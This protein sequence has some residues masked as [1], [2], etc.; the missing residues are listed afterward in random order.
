VSETDSKSSSFLFG[1]LVSLARGT[2]I[3]MQLR[4]KNSV[5][6]RRPQSSYGLWALALP[7]VRLELPG[8]G[9]VLSL[10]RT[11]VQ[12]DDRWREAGWQEIRCKMH[13]YRVRLDLSSSFD[14][15]TYFLARYC[16]LDTELVMRQMLRPG[17]QFID[18]GANIG[19]LTLMAAHLVGPTG[20]IHAFEPNPRM[21]QRLNEH[22]D[23]NGLHDRVIA[24]PVG[25]SN[26]EADLPF[27]IVDGGAESGTVA[28]LPDDVAA[29]VTEQMTIHVVPGDRLLGGALT[30]DRRT[31]IKLDVEGH[32][33]EAVQGM[34]DT[35]DRLRPV[36]LTEVIPERFSDSQPCGLFP[37]LFGRGYRCLE[38]G[39]SRTSMRGH[40]LTLRPVDGLS[41]LREQCDLLWLPPNQQYGFE[42]FITE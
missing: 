18:G 39:L 10:A 25:L 5:H 42:R 27:R 16:E 20:H 14:R 35:L 28:P 7:W 15:T 24:H 26:R 41:D 37:L 9:K 6:G 3:L 11:D 29:H 21:Y 17:D 23:L 32:E 2:A 38:L 8:W 36:V 19:M 12:H 31:L 33:A 4:P 30:P 34:L 1:W 13:G 22:I 40:Q